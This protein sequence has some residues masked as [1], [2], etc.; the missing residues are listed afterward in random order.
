MTGKERM[1]RRD[2]DNGI[3]TSPWLGGRAGRSLWPWGTLSS[4]ISV[5]VLFLSFFLCL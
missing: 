3:V 2:M 5:F 1:H 4:Q